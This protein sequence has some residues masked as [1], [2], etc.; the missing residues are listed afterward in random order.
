VFAGKPEERH[1]S[2]FQ[3]STSEGLDIYVH[4]SLEVQPQGM[5]IT[6]DKWTFMKRLRVKGVTI[7][8]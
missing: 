3:H 6:L 7:T 8:Q 2:S 5:E 4:P 1:L